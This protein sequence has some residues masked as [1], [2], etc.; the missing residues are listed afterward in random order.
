MMRMAAGL[1]V[2]RCYMIR[3]GINVSIE[4]SGWKGMRTH[5]Q[6]IYHIMDTMVATMAIITAEPTVFFASAPLNRYLAD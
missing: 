2:R 1:Y 3:M 5:P 4:L 6:H